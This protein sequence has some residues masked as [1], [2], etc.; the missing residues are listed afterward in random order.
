MIG[1]IIEYLKEYGNISFRESPM[2][3]VDSLVLCQFAYLKFDGIVPGVEENLPS[4]KLKDLEEHPDYEKLYADERYEKV[5]RKLVTAMLAGK[6]YRNMKM[7]C[8]VNFIEK[9][10]E[11][12]FSAVTLILDDGTIYVAFRGTDE[13]IVGWKEDFNM[14]FLSP[15]PGQAYSVEYLNAVGARL[16][17]PFYVGGHSK[18][19]NLAV[20]SSMNCRPEI[21]DRIIRIYS[22][23]G[24]GFR[25]EVLKDANYS[26]IARRVVKIL[27]HSSL[28]GMLFESD[29]HFKVVESRTFG[30]LQHNPYTW[31]VKDG[32][33]VEVKD[34]YESRKQMDNT[35]NEWILSL[36][37]EQLRVFVDTLFQV[38]NASQAEDLI[39]FTA[40]WR[41]SMNGIVAALKEVDEQTAG[42]LKEVIKSLFDIAGA[43]MRQNV[44]NSTA[45]L[46]QKLK[47]QNRTEGDRRRA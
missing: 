27:P 34:I 7:N 3:E 47:I 32:K 26:M 41:K 46:K 28:V 6:R 17:R 19:G 45:Q 1:T 16:H 29:M 44:M 20:Y 36:D 23:D 31:L 2:N 25:P 24:P 5:N 15:V 35:L 4:V 8:Y 18:G 42:I 43:R 12:Q 39:Q 9:E 33:L 11:T 10:W 21:Q 14:A 40:E 30:L 22:M 38:I 37:E 13:T